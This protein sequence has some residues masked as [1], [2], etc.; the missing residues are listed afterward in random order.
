MRYTKLTSREL[1][2]EFH[3]P[4]LS[5]DWKLLH[6]HEMGAIL[7]EGKEEVKEI[8]ALFRELLAGSDKPDNCPDDYQTIIL[9]YLLALESIDRETFDIL[10]AFSKTSRKNRMIYKKAEELVI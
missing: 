8:E 2:K 7:L 1:I 4:D 6:L 10:E 9:R 3:S 5:R